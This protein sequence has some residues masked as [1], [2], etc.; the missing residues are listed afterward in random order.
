MGRSV[1]DCEKKMPRGNNRIPA[2]SAKYLLVRFFWQMTNSN[3][4]TI[5]KTIAEI[6]N[7]C[8]KI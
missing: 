4:K 5:E 7:S 3:A 1:G 6:I 2:K 8:A